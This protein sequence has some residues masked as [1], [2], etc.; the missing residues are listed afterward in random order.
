MK[1]EDPEN[2]SKKAVEKRWL[3]TLEVRNFLDEQSEPTMSRRIQPDMGTTL[4]Q[5]RKR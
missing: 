2:R 5:Q 1:I 3:V 4:R